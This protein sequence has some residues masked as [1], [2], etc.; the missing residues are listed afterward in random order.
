MFNYFNKKPI[1]LQNDS[2]R[3]YYIQS[4]NDSIKRLVEKYD[5]QK[6]NKYDVMLSNNSENN[7]NQPIINILGFLGFLSI[8]TT[9]FY[10]YRRNY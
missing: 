6:I 4:T 2:L 10:F 3:Q 8:S 7:N 1:I 9:A 5:S